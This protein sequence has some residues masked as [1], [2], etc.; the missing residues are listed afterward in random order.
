VGD[1]GKNCCVLDRCGFGGLL[2]PCRKFRNNG[3]DCVDATSN[4]QRAKH[5]RQRT[6]LIL[7]DYLKSMLGSLLESLPIAV[8]KI[9]TLIIPKRTGVFRG[10]IRHTLDR[11]TNIYA[12][13]C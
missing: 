6:K 12:L 7:A 11:L 10:T 2:A 13:F 3:S 5:P 4:I 9:P 1:V 8:C